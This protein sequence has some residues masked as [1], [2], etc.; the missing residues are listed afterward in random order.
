[1]TGAREDALALDVLRRVRPVLAASGVT[2]SRVDCNS[3]SGFDLDVH[4]LVGA[5]VGHRVEQA[6]AVRVLD[7]VA[8]SGRRFGQVDVHVDPIGR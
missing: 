8:A 5:P 1:M 3:T 7:A 4:V 6:V 2:A